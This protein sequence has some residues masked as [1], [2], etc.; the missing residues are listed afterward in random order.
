MG[1]I[2]GG[3]PPIP[4]P[5]NGGPPIPPPGGGPMPIP[6]PGGPPGGPPM[7][8]PPILP[9]GASASPRSSDAITNARKPFM[10][11]VDHHERKLPSSFSFTTKVLEGKIGAG[12]KTGEPPEGES[13]KGPMNPP[14]MDEVCMRGCQM[15]GCTH[16]HLATDEVWMHQR[17][18]Q[19][20][21]TVI[22]MNSE[23]TIL[24]CVCVV[25]GRLVGV[26]EIVNPPYSTHCPDCD[27]EPEPDDVGLV[28]LSYGYGTG[29]LKVHCF[30]CEKILDEVRLQG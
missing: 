18:H 27:P 23:N 24:S 21:P 14:Q 10:P 26:W 7:G 25:C 4:P 11:Y 13:M 5:P 20:A 3:G 22:V 1:G 19:G 15:P 9:P 12:V 30:E 29:V 8:G 2:P 17:C 16:A 28:R 6:I